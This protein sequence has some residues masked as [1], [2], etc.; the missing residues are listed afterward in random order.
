MDILPQCTGSLFPCVLSE[1]ASVAKE[2]AR[3]R[4][5][6]K[7]T[8]AQRVMG[9]TWRH[10]AAAY[11][12][13]SPLLS[14]SWTRGVPFVK[15]V[16]E[17]VDQQRRQASDRATARANAQAAIRM[18]KRPPPLVQVIT[19]LDL[20]DLSYSLSPPAVDAP[21]S[22][23]AGT[24]TLPVSTRT[25]PLSNN[26]RPQTSF[27]GEVLP[28]VRLQRT[29]QFSPHPTFIAPPHHEGG[30]QVIEIPAPP[31]SPRL[32]DR[33]PASSPPP[34]RRL[35]RIPFE[36][37]QLH[38]EGVIASK[39]LAIVA[40]RD[41]QRALEA[42]TLALWT[43]IALIIALSAFFGSFYGVDDPPLA[44]LIAL[45]STLFIACLW[46]GISIELA[47]YQGSR[48]PPILRRDRNETRNLILNLC[49]LISDISR[50][51]KT[52][53]ARRPLL[54]SA[55]HCLAEAMELLRLYEGRH[56]VLRHFRV[57][58]FAPFVLLRHLVRSIHLR[59]FSRLCLLWNIGGDYD[60]RYAD[61]LQA[62]RETGWGLID[63]AIWPKETMK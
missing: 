57:L 40:A 39:R 1:C 45:P 15:K 29:V 52:S 9:A 59:T 17:I 60:R 54:T 20:P 58:L 8:R 51:D 30:S 7:A 62:G 25:K 42:P 50:L 55:S 41:R 23:L 27:G 49:R 14:L 21:R 28:V 56:R 43:C 26:A 46:I 32:A 5:D 12:Q 63:L 6:L 24:Y 44:L 33:P 19:Q 61:E 18:S 34:I 4:Q 22:S 10:P 35:P 2:A 48:I 13:T 31:A 16:V 36:D 47:R 53:P 38:I 11:A 37:H 3:D